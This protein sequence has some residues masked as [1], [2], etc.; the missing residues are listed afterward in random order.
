[1]IWD[2][3]TIKYYKGQPSQ[4]KP[5]VG[6]MGNR[7]PVLPSYLIYVFKKTQQSGFLDTIFKLLNDSKF[8]K[9]LVQTKKNIGLIWILVYHLW[10][11]I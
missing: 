7:S 2:P 3:K 8:F 5:I 4:P 9:I 11:R 10:A 6:L 1:M